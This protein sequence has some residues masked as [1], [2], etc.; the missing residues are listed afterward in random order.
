MGT[1]CQ[2]VI[3]QKKEARMQVIW[4]NILQAGE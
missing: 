2:A 4:V 3:S 1:V